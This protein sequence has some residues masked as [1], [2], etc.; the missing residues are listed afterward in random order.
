MS[1]GGERRQITIMFCDLVGSTALS[2]RL[3]P[4]ELG[5]VIKDFQFEAEALVESFEGHVAQYLGDGLLIYFGYPR[6]HENDAER[7]VRAGLG[8]VEATRALDQRWLSRLGE[9]LRVRIG[10]HTGQ[11]LIDEIGG[12]G[13]QD[14]L[15][16]GE[17]PNVAARLQALAPPGGVVV[18]V[19]TRTLVRGRFDFEDLGLHTLKGIT[20]PCE[21]SRVVR[22]VD[23]AERLDAA[24]REVM[25]PLVG[26]E[27]E[28]GLLRDRWQQAQDGDGQVV[29]ISGEAGLGKSRLLRELRDTLAPDVSTVLHFE[30]SPFHGNSA[31]YPLLEHLERVLLLRT[32]TGPNEKLVALNRFCVGAHGL[33]AQQAG[34]IASLLGIRADAP[35]AA[36]HGT[37]QQREDTLAAMVDLT[38]GA[39]TERGAL[40]LFEDAHWADPTTLEFLELLIARVP[41]TRLLVVITHRPEFAPSWSR[42][43]SVATFSLSTLSR[44]Q[45]GA[46][47]SRLT[48]GKP[49]PAAL[50]E[51][52]VTK[53]GGIPLFLEEV[54]RST[55]ESGQLR[56]TADGYEFAAG[57]AT[58][59][60]PMTL[61]DSLMARLDR[62]PGA[63]DIAQVGAVIGRE[64]DH[65]LLAAMA[66]LDPRALA[67]GL[68]KLVEAGLIF[69]RGTGAQAI[70]TFKHALVQDAAYESITRARKQVLHRGI[71]ESMERI[72]VN[73]G[74]AAPELIA[75]HWTESGHIEAA[76]PYWHRAAQRALERCTNI[77]AIGH[78]TRGIEL[79]D[80]LPE[81]AQRMQLKLALQIALGAPL[82]ATK[83]YA[84]PEVK[85]SF[86]RARQLCDT[87]RDTP[88]LFRVLWGLAAYYLIRADLPTARE[89]AQRCLEQAER[90]GDDD[91]LLEAHTWVGTIHFYMA[92]IGA[93]QFHFAAA[94]ARYDAA[95]HHRHA[96][97]Y[98][99]DPAILSM[100]HVTWMHWLGGHSG[101][102]L[103][104]EGATL[105]LARQV[106]HPLSIAHALNF[107][108]VHRHYRREPLQTQLSADEEVA[109]ATEHQ[110]PHYVAYGTILSGWARAAQGDLA[111]GIAQ[112]QQGLSARRATGAELAR[113]LFLTLLAQAHRADGNTE[114][115]LVA[116]KDAQALIASTG[117][118]WWEPEVHR[119][120]G[121]LL[122]DA[123]P[124]DD[125]PARLEQARGHFHHAL[126]VAHGQSS[127]AL[128][129]RAATSLLRFARHD[130]SCDPAQACERLVKLLGEL[131]TEADDADAREATGLLAQEWTGPKALP[132]LVATAAAEPS[133]QAPPRSAALGERQ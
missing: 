60:V 37:K 49:L 46:V 47:V 133:V 98:G 106:A 103:D 24:A 44:R 64:F 122:V 81:T 116:L 17:A 12:G 109:I 108:A 105:S 54:T 99:L 73:A 93:A 33:S 52:I 40:M 114:A 62:H 4:E 127:K 28:L 90:E 42:L 8:I 51:D 45:A 70:Y 88:Q 36:G 32:K 80:R 53:T 86:N 66:P 79:L 39:A 16:L 68:G 10:I 125:T 113:P 117:E 87:L 50:L 112:M 111:G 26:R 96:L 65:L 110:F 100:V 23:T 3:D 71:A 104:N 55:L 43:G 41:R 126:G 38:C 31:Y 89:L 7:A 82:I 56:E 74:Q 101:L 128:E 9:P 59:P 29:L 85:E 22:V 6:A 78:L 34:L 67:L 130:G 21:V 61:R 14:R 119:L 35:Q 13:R 120:L 92:E 115:A 102:A 20:E 124:H 27:Q 63:K 97:E 91:Q 57:S 132:G 118:R 18:S 69:K 5:A 48:R 1:R 76:I 15:A 131:G 72:D 58:L 75:H 95:R 77:E 2:H 11:V 30:C 83:G 84:A 94:L 19:Q 123:A 121:E 25:T 129:L 107:K